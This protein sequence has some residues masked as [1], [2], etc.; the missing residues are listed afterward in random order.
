MITKLG[1]WLPFFVQ[2]MYMTGWREHPSQQKAKRRGSATI[3]FSDIQKEFAPSENWALLLQNVR[4]MLSL[5]S[6]VLFSLSF[7]TL[8]TLGFLSPVFPNPL[9]LKRK[10]IHGERKELFQQ[11]PRSFI[12]LLFKKASYFW[13][14]TFAES[15]CASVGCINFLWE[16]I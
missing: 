6:F 14:F 3:S 10:T 8:L 9:D 7:A 1:L 12:F 2:V 15:K 16:I 11:L 5:S 4:W 13:G